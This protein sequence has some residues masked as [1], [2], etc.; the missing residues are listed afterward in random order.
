M[1]YQANSPEEYIS[2]LPEDRQEPIKKLR[3]IIKKNLPDGFE[4]TIN[5]SMIGYVV[6]HSIYPDGYHCTP[7]L[8]LPFMSIASQKNFIAVYSSSVYA[9]KDLYNWFVSEYP[10]HCKRKID[11]GKS[12][13]RFKYMDD[14]PF[15]LIGELASKMTVKEW[16]SIYE[17]AIKK[18]PKK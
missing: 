3:K 16:I 15:E 2:Q 13:I 8:P 1:Q 14:I 17:E 6:P 18:Q 9:T 5:Y 11:M 10:K 4:E 12:C 7:E